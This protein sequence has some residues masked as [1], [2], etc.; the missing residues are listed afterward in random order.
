[1]G[2]PY[3]YLGGFNRTHSKPYTRQIV[4]PSYFPKLRI[5]GNQKPSLGRHLYI[6]ETWFCFEVKGSNIF[7]RNPEN[8]TSDLSNLVD[9]EILGSRDP[10][11]WV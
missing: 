3:L 6:V 8:G 10:N 1:M 9:L 2:T 11:I 7:L 4:G 5:G